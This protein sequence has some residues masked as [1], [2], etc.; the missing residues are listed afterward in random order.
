MVV[1]ALTPALTPFQVSCCFYTTLVVKKVSEVSEVS[2]T[3]FSLTP[4]KC[5]IYLGFLPRCQRCQYIGQLLIYREKTRNTGVLP[6]EVPLQPS[7]C[8]VQT[9]LD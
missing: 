5:L 7:P 6:P 9:V 4:V 2:V 3:D 8:L 1:G